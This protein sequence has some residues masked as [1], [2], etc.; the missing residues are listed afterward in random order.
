MDRKSR[1]AERALNYRDKE[2]VP[3]IHLNLH[4]DKAK[5]PERTHRVAPRET[6]IRRAHTHT[7]SG[8]PPPDT[9]RGQRRT[10]RRRRHAHPGKTHKHT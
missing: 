4:E 8:S 7:H 6:P 10:D 1:D 2:E 3:K 9:N 5:G